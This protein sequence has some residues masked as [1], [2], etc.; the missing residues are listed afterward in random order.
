MQISSFENVKHRFEIGMG[1]RETARSKIVG[2]T[3]IKLQAHLNE[4]LKIED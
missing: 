1:R 2:N 4:K 3:S